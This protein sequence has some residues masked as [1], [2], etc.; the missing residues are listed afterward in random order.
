MDQDNPQLTHHIAV[1][2]VQ[3]KVEELE[4]LTTKTKVLLNTIGPYAIHGQPVV[5][6]C[7]HNGTHYLDVT[8]ESPWVKEMIEKYEKAAQSSHAVVSH[9]LNP[10]T[11][12]SKADEH[13]II[14]Q[15]GIESVPSDILSY[16]MVNR[17]HAKTS[18]PVREV[19]VSMHSMKGAPSGGT[20]ATVINLFE[21]YSISQI[22]AAA[23]PDS[24]SPIAV[25]KPSYTR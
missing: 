5:A 15:A 12:M 13:Q 10:V 24:M 8:G 7:A 2:I 16:V 1:E 19:I 20:L 22:Q 4:S 3:L 25:A 6:A 17:L 21:Q 18:Q 9:V 14:S 23:R 11:S